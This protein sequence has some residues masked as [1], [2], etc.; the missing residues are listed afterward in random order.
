MALKSKDQLSTE[1]EENLLQTVLEWINPFLTDHSQ[2]DMEGWDKPNNPRWW[3]QQEW[4]DPKIWSYWLMSDYYRSIIESYNNMIAF[5][6]ATVSNSITA[7][8]I[9][10]DFKL[11]KMVQYVQANSYIQSLRKGADK[12]KEEA[13]SKLLPDNSKELDEKLASKL[14]KV[15][16]ATE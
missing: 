4:Y 1:E 5:E 16:V 13:R 3:L 15:L 6:T 10:G 2:F 12:N 7:S 14:Q 9:N 8:G 11:P